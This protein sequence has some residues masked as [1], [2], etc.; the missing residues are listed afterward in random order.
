MLSRRNDITHFAYIFYRINAALT[1]V[2]SVLMQL[3]L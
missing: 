2:K 1:V 3:L